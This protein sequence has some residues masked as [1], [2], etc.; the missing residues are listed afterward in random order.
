MKNTGP[1]RRSVLGAS[2]LLLIFS[3]FFPYWEALLASDSRADG[4]EL[5]IYVTHAGGPLREQLA[6]P[7]ELLRLE[8]ST[9]AAAALALVLL[10][11][12]AALAQRPWAFLLCVPAML[13]PAA[14]GA[15]AAGYFAGCGTQL[16]ARPG[17]G[18]FI[19]GGAAALLAAA[20]LR[21]FWKISRRA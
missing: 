6:A 21:E 15:D 2:G 11:A 20:V 17:A 5:L 7:E 9:A 1:S 14:V 3:F 19:A 12:A 16:V 4:L 13:L 10:L 8:H 18:A